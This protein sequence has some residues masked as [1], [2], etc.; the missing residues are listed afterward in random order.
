MDRR[1]RFRMDESGEWTSLDR[2][3]GPSSR[4]SG[5]SSSG[6]AREETAAAVSAAT[7]PGATS[8]AATSPAATGTVSRTPGTS[9]RGVSTAA[10]GLR[11]A[12]FSAVVYTSLTLAVLLAALHALPLG[13]PATTLEPSG[14]RVTVIA[15]FQ[16]A[17]FL[18]AAQRERAVVLPALSAGA[19]TE[20]VYTNL[21]AARAAELDVRKSG[22]PAAEVRDGGYYYVVLGPTAAPR[23][24]GLFAAALRRAEVP[25]FFHL[26][27]FS[28]FSIPLPQYHPAQ[29]RMAEQLAL[30]DS[31]A[32]ADL[33]AKDAGVP[34]PQLA[35]WEGT[36]R[37]SADIIHSLPPAGRFTGRLQA[38][39]SSVAAAA[40]SGNS[41]A[42][43]RMA[44]LDRCLEA[45]AAFRGSL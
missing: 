25:S 18:D 32:L 37:R 41:S 5:A 14:K 9:A 31:Q 40:A 27:S 8:P 13:A 12:L 39:S 11:D 1:L 20:G 28:S 15:D 44:A 29:L 23:A 6:R 24:N 10:G 45:Y 26:F 42:L 4:A 16:T 43:R 38:L 21:A 19:Y 35:Q 36:V 30:A 7:V 22:V 34:A 2:G 33:M 3:T 17:P